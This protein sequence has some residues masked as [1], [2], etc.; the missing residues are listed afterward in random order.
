MDKK[1]VIE[2]TKMDKEDKKLV[3]LA[4]IV[5]AIVFGLLAIAI[6]ADCILAN[7]KY[8]QFYE[9]IQE[10][11]TLYINGTEVDE[12]NIDIHLYPYTHIS[13]N[14]EEK[15]IYLAFYNRGGKLWYH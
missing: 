12:S 9:K 5:S 4:I 13:F 8:E 3:K 6:T 2:E 14:D 15:K 7:Q 1:Y 10:N 11:Y